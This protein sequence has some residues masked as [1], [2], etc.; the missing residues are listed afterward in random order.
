MK[1]I[2]LVERHFEKAVTVLVALLL[3]G[4]L[5]YDYLQPQIVKMGTKTDVG[6]T[7]VNGQLA[8]QAEQ[9]EIK[10]NSQQ[11]PIQFQSFEPGAAKKSYQ[12]KLGEIVSSQPHEIP[13][14]A[15]SLATKLMPKEQVGV[16]WWYQPTFAAPIMVS[17]VAW[18]GD[19]LEPKATA[20]NQ[21]LQ[22]FVG[23]TSNPANLD[24]IWTKPTARINLKDIRA[25]YLKEDLAKN[26]PRK[27][28]PESWRNNAVYFIDVVFQR[29]EQ[30]Q[31]GSWGKE[32]QVPL[33]F[34][35]DLFRGKT[36]T[37]RNEIFAILREQS[38][39]T[40]ICQ[41]D[42][43]PTQI[44]N[45]AAGKKTVASNAG[46][47]STAPVGDPKKIK[48]LEKLKAELADVQTKLQEAG[49]EWDA[50]M[51]KKENADRKKKGSGGDSG[52]GGGGGSGVGGGASG[53]ASGGETSGTDKRKRLALTDK[54]RDLAKKVKVLTKELASPIT[55]PIDPSENPEQGTAIESDVD[56]IDVWIHDLSVPLGKTF[57]YRCQVQIF[58]QFFGKEFLLVKEQLEL[59]KEFAINTPWSQWSE[60]IYVPKKVMYFADSGTLGVSGARQSASFNVY[61]LRKGAWYKM[62]P[63]PS[64]EPGQSIVFKEKLD[65]EN[66]SATFV[67]TDSGWF[68]VDV[69]DDPNA[70]PEKNRPN[71]PAVVLRR[72]DGEGAIEIRYPTIDKKNPSII[73]L[74]NLVKETK[75]NKPA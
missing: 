15:P 62:D 34:G 46:N 18:F 44:K 4:Y 27:V 59:A 64:F 58:N 41:P 57:R 11:N 21:K 43:Y 66:S 20:K 74:E 68:V 2:S 73:L 38:V 9:L 28:A 8:K 1:G 54:F 35:A 25:E 33:M 42:F 22:E 49:G 24:V 69:I 23:P 72:Q 26:P 16:N 50:E 53:G 60:P 51:A 47:Q 63:N 56:F 65:S 17:P 5:A 10:Q 61:T 32:E 3:C 29:Q 30:F 14:N 12:S 71:L 40:Q 75:K 70:V 67:E 48:D 13:K 7:D 45:S 55:K 36:F 37:N 52:G 6:P 31:D 39:E 19:A